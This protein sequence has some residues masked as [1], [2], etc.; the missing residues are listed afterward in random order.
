MNFLTDTHALLWWFTDSPKISPNV[1]EIFE[2][3]E[4]GKNI[5]FIPSIVIAE[6]LS[7]FD[8]KR[9]SFDFN[10][11]LKKIND[12]ENFMLIPLDYPVLRKMVELTDIT[13]LHD[14]IIASTAK[15]LNLPVIT[16]DKTLQNLSHIKTIW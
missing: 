14:K 2:K 6:A 5:I 16:K 12:S 9:I 11:L 15:Y 7:I 1:S 3:C 10:K 8:K 4:N 13:E